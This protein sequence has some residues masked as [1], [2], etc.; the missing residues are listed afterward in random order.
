MTDQIYILT[1]E[2]CVGTKVAFEFFADD[3][4]LAQDHAERLIESRPGVR[5]DFCSFKGADALRSGPIRA[6]YQRKGAARQR[7]LGAVYI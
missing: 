5:P 3:N 7:A 2:D 4:H 6:C 1:L